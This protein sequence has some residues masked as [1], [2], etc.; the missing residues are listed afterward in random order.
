MSFGEFFSKFNIREECNKFSTPLWQCPQFLFVI[1]GFL[2]IVSV[3]LSFALGE[4]YISNPE[5]TI[6]FILTLTGVLLVIAFTITKSFERLGEASRLKSEFISIVSHQLRSPLT[7]LKWGLDFLVNEGASRNTKE[8]GYFAILKDNLDRMHELVNDLLTVSRAEQGTLPFQE[9]E[10]EL[11][12]IVKHVLVEFQSV[13]QA[14]RIA[15]KVERQDVPKLHT[16][17]SL[18]HHVLSNLVDNAIR[19]AWTKVEPTKG[20]K[21][22]ESRIVIRYL[23]EGQNVKVEVEDNGAGIP[24]G[25]QKYIFQKFFRSNNAMKLQTEG[26][27]LG[28][29]IVKSLLERA[30]GQVGFTSAESTGSTFWFTIP[31]RATVR[32]EKTKK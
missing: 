27:G 32:Q 29:Y 13:T 21:K 12:D 24:A 20:S 18:V 28:L 6:L 1:M 31:I 17:S 5:V 8:A 25:D 14:S 22:E 26:S 7:N 9:E 19:Y 30:G 10:F 4:R 2:I 3:L 23:Q 15:I 16:D 11:E